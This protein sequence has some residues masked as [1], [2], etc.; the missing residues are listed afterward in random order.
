M[1]SSGVRSVAKALPTVK[2][3]SHVLTGGI[4]NA[5][6]DTTEAADTVSAAATNLDHGAASVNEAADTIA[7]A[8]TNLD[9]G[10]FSGTEAAD[11]ITAA[12]TNVDHGASS[13]TDSDTALAAG[14]ILIQATVSVA[15]SDSR[16]RL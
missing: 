14:T 15:D 10:S 7:A 13:P 4:S 6:G 1:V 9:H 5:V 2:N 8:A 12:A 3:F 16:L 11:T